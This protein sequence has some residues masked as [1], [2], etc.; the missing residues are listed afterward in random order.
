MAARC[1]TCAR[2]IL[3]TGAAGF[4]GSHV[5]DGLMAAGLDVR[6][7]DS[8]SPAAHTVRP[9]YLNPDAEF[10]QGDVRDPDTLRRALRGVDAVCHQAAMVGLG[11]DLLDIEDY[12]SHNDI[13]TAVLLRQLAVAD[14]SGRLVLASSMVVY[15]EGAYQCAE[16]GRVGASPRSGQPRIVAVRAAL[17]ALRR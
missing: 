16:H 6:M 4:I 10:I 17:P 5:V 3:L 15:G 1:L 13:G 7:L 14:F 11:V 12:V 2:M 9:N 8:L